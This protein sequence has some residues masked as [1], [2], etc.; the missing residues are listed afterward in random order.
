MDRTIR[1]ETLNDY[2]TVRRYLKGLTGSVSNA[3]FPPFQFGFRMPELSS[4]H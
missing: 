2:Q 4:S 3:F 1:G